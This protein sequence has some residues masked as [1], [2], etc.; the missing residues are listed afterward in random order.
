[1]CV[2]LCEFEIYIYIYIYIYIGV[3]YI[4]LVLVYIILFYESIHICP[5]YLY[6]Y[7]WNMCVATVVISDYEVLYSS[8][9][10]YILFI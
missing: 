8:S 2:P 10:T 5:Q 6:Y 3:Y 7:S 1:M 4:I 9:F